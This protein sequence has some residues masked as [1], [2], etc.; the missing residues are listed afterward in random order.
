MAVGGKQP[1]RNG[2]EWARTLPLLLAL[3]MLFLLMGLMMRSCDVG[4]GHP[5]GAGVVS[6]GRP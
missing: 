1:V 3:P 5:E 6:V 4:Y 2:R